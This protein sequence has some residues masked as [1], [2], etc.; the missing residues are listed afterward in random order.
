M[1][2]YKILFSMKHASIVL[3]TQ[4]RTVSDLYGLKSGKKGFILKAGTDGE[5]S[6]IS[7]RNKRVGRFHALARDR[8]DKRTSFECHACAGIFYLHS[9][10]FLAQTHPAVPAAQQSA[11]VGLWTS[12]VKIR[13]RKAI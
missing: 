1:K 2:A 10:A 13:T 12:T 4:K 3:E 8:K 11:V 6:L 9:F 5:C 7:L